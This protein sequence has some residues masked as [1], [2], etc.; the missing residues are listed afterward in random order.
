MG[1]RRDGDSG[2]GIPE[3]SAILQLKKEELMEVAL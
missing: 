2:R 1:E 3:G